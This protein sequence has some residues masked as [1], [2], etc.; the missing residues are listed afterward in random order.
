MVVKL[1]SESET[2]QV[3]WCSLK[4]NQNCTAN[5][6]GVTRNSKYLII[7]IVFHCSLFKYLKEL[8]CNCKKVLVTFLISVHS[9][10]ICRQ[11]N[12]ERVLL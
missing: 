10:V 5:M 12:I 9:H 2:T 6:V 1:N 8:K 11:E 4:I 7:L 3:L